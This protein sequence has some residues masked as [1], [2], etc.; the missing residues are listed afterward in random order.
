MKFAAALFLTLTAAGTLL[1]TGCYTRTLIPEEVL[2][3]PTHAQVRTAYNLWYRTPDDL[4]PENIQQGK[5]IPFGTDVQIESM[6][7]SQIVFRANGELFTL[8][9]DQTKT[10]IPMED[11]ARELFTTALAVETASGAT[12][13]QFEKMRRG[14]IEKGMTRKQVLITYGR[15]SRI[16]TPNILSDTWIYW[17]DRVKS[18]RVIF[19]NDKVLTELTLD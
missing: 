11:F 8:N 18:K 17:L 19:K 9:Y 10:T 14:V 5:I 4:T 3:L 2:Q 16:R 12:P 1:F 15:P 6:T 13:A 7:D